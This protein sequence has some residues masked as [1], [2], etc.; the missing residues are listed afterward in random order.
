MELLFP[1][2]AI[3]ILC[4]T[5]IEMLRYIYRYIRYPDRRAVQKRLKRISLNT[6]DFSERPT[7]IIK[8]QAFSNISS[9]NSI[10]GKFEIFHRLNILVYKAN[11]KNTLGFY[12]LLSFLFI[13]T[14]FFIFKAFNLPIYIIVPL[15]I[16]TGFIPFFY[17]KIKKNSRMNKFYV[18]LP[19]A[20]DLI[21]RSLKAGHAF[22]SG[23]KLAAEELPD[24]IGTEF[25]Y[26]VEEINYGINVPDALKNLMKRVDCPDL[27]FFVISVIL[28][29]ETGGN[30]AEIIMNTASIIRE[31][32]K[33]FDKVKTLT[34]EAKMTMRVLFSLPFIVAIA[35]YFLNR[36]YVRILWEDPIGN[37][38]L[39]AGVVM[40]ILGI[41][42]IRKIID[43]KV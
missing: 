25:S 24:P 8:Q 34:A 17:L 18:Q 3:F 6:L 13:F 37:I 33:L 16:F 9:L 11:V 36:D 19:V 35:M 23:L 27:N 42:I 1:A 26:C 30:L 5:V 14:S 10:M 21:A 15:L 22:N 28:Q 43:L 12:F 7:N 39:Y 29:R 38:L 40:L 41:L 32:F 31:R 2:F 20:L 4:I